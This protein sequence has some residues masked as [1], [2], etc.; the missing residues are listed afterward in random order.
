MFGNFGKRPPG[1]TESSSARTEPPSSR[2]SEPTS[3][4][5]TT[6]PLAAMTTPSR[7]E[8]PTRP[9]L[10]PSRSPEPVKAAA[11]TP[12]A[13]KPGV[14][15]EGFECEG[16]IKFGG[17]LHLDG[18]FKGDLSVGNLTIGNNGHCEGSVSCSVL[19]IK[20]H[21]EGTA[22]CE[23]LEIDPSAIVRANIQYGRI[24][25]AAGAEVTGKL[26]LKV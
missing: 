5:S 18:T 22:V 19:T 1:D 4:S 10:P 25:V 26:S 17:L 16:R 11:P 12:P 7:P 3:S 23:E 9:E 20:G 24:R 13:L 21:F 2:S 6:N 15:S 8:L 14:I